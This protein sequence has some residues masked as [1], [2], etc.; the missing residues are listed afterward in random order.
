MDNIDDVMKAMSGIQNGFRNNRYGGDR[1]GANT[2]IATGLRKRI[3]PHSVV[4]TFKS[5]GKIR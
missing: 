4:N 2:V 5:E 1:P 3:V